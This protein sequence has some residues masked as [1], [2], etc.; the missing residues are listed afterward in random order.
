MNQPPAQ[1]TSTAGSNSNEDV[2]RR[3]NRPRNRNRKNKDGQWGANQKKVVGETEE[4]KDN[5]FQVG[6]RS[7]DRYNAIVRKIAEYVARKVTDGGEF[8][9]A[10]NPDDPDGMHFEDIK[11]PKKPSDMSDVAEVKL[12]R[13]DVRAA[14]DRITKRKEACRAAFSIIIGQCTEELRNHI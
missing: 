14:K 7:A 6:S 11:I 3:G 2:S 12:W 10:L 5:A 4:L 1:A 13:I 8:I 9:T